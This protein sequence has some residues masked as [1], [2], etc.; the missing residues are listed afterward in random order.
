MEREREHDR[1][2]QV[3]EHH[4][5]LP[6]GEEAEVVVDR[7][8][9]AQQHAPTAAPSRIRYSQPYGVN[10]MFMFRTSVQTM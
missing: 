10:T 2:R 7:M 4:D 9:R 5:E 6:A 3:H 1:D 8:Q